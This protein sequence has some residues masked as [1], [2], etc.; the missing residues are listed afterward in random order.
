MFA[1]QR[2]LFIT[3]ILLFLFTGCSKRDASVNEAQ[4]ILVSSS[5]PELATT[6]PP[7][8]TA[9]SVHPS[10]TPVPPTYTPLPVT[11]TPK[12]TATPTTLPEDL[13]LVNLKTQDGFNLV[14]YL[15]QP[16]TSP[17]HPIAVL[18]AHEYYSSHQSWETFAE[19]LVE[20]GFPTLT[21]DFRGHGDSP[22]T[23]DFSSVGNDV[24][25][26]IRY[27]NQQGFKKI[28]CMGASM[29][30]TGCMAAAKEM[31]LIGLVN[32]SGPQDLGAGR[33]VTRQDLENLTIPKIFMIAEEDQ[34]GTD[35]VTDFIEMVETTA[36]PKEFY[37]YPGYAHASGLL[38][39]D[40]G[41]EVQEILL[42][43]VKGFS[44]SP[45]EQPAVT[46]I[47]CQAAGLPE[48]A[49]TGVS[50]NDEWTPIIR[51]FDSIP[52]TLVPAGCFIMGYDENL[53]EEQP[54]HEI[55]FEQPFWIDLTE[56]TVAQFAQF[57]NGQVE[58]VENYTYWLDPG[59]SVFPTA[60]QLIFQGNQWIP[61]PARVNHALE[62]V[63]WVGAD[64]YCAWRS[65]RLPT[66]AEWEYSARGPDSLLYP[67]GDE[68]I[69][70][71]VVR[72]LSR[73][74]VPEVGSKPRGASWV[75]ALDMSSSLFEWTSST[76]QPYPYNAFDGREVSILE[77]ETS[78]RV[79][80]GSAWY[81]PDGMHDNVSATA[82]FS[83][84]PGYA[85]W[86]Y[87]FRC[88]QSIGTGG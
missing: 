33:L 5:T 73:N 40:N 20:A 67:W 27:L 57:L 47:D 8:P 43:F 74:I 38:F 12:P 44:Q 25:A 51:E 34:A 85:A 35:F 22:G 4:V 53:P 79:F 83:A 1:H 81:H 32:L 14:G 49:C 41:E 13:E 55:C 58:P 61:M 59:N 70:D 30:G 76:Y 18:L 84:P 2:K 21:F 16:K 42:N 11:N 54:V 60:K 78:H 6:L 17:A 7:T 68:F 80:R 29:G 77:D 39:E 15:H 46:T 88:A 65:A 75:G 37:L 69:R 86:Y 52:M 28:I 26:A 87:G 9:T 45:Q 23:K 63:R 3:I 24:K 64:A 19:R 10:S 66:E 31:E 82:R 62:S 71:N 48:K 72:W 50:T 36:E 56:V